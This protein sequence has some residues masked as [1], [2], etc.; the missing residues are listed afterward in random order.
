[1]PTINPW[2]NQVLAAG[3]TFNGG[4]MAIGTDATDNAINIGTVANAGR[5]EKRRKNP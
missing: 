2:G 1:M 3:V 4:T 5:K